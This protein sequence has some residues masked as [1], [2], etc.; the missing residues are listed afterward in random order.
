[1]DD[2]ISRSAIIKYLEDEY[3]GMLSDECMYIYQI[4]EFIDNFPKAN[5]KDKWIPVSEGLPSIYDDVYVT[6]D[7]NDGNG[8]FT[9]FAYL[10]TG[11]WHGIDG[12]FYDKDKI[13]AWMYL[14]SYSPYEAYKDE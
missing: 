13:K 4:I 6:I 12:K 10:G 3:H 9:D 14:P 7:L 2:L 11:C 1:M 5:G 8:A